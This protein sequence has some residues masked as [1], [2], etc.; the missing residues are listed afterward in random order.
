MMMMMIIIIIVFIITTATI[1][2]ANGVVEW[3]L[4]RAPDRQPR[5][6]STFVLRYSVL[7][8]MM[9]YYIDLYV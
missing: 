7:E 9:L 8:D 5:V 1:I 3:A 2:A 4:P 6:C